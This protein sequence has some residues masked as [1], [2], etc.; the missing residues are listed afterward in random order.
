MNSSTHSR[1]NTVGSLGERPSTTCT[2]LI[3]IPIKV[4]ATLLKPTKDCS[5]RITDEC[6][7][8]VKLDSINISA[9]TKKQNLLSRKKSKDETSSYLFRKSQASSKLLEKQ[10]IHYEGTPLSLN[11][12]ELEDERLASVLEARNI[13]KLRAN[14][15]STMRLMIGTPVTTV[16][17]KQRIKTITN[18]EGRLALEYRY[19]QK[20]EIELRKEKK[21]MDD[22]VGSEL[23]RINKNF[24]MVKEMI[25]KKRKQDLKKLRRQEDDDY[26]KK[27]QILNDNRDLI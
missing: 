18:N 16:C 15:L 8:R 6:R 9:K 3:D 2:R 22:M 19:L 10:I 17:P 5:I 20:D 24:P 7:I 12:V 14:Q 26:Q 21:I 25:D 23:D 27:L 11:Q 4:S 1:P 13:K